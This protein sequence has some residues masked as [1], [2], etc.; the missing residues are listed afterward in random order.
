MQRLTFDTTQDNSSPLWSPDGTRIVFA[1]RRD[2]KWGLYVKSANGTGNEELIVDSEP[3]KAPMSWSP[4]GKILVYWQFG[5]LGDIWAVP[6]AGDKKA[7]PILQSAFAEVFP[8][9]SP[10]GKW[11]AYQSN[12]TGR[13]E[14]YIKPFPDGPGKWQVSTD[15]GLWPRWRG[16]GKELYFVLA[17]SMWAVDIRVTGSSPEAG[18]PQMLF[19]L[20]GDPSASVA[21]H[22]QYHR[23]AVTADGERFLLSQLSG[24]ASTAGGLADAVA[25]AADGGGAQLVGISPNGVTVVVNWPQMMK[26]N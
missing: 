18:V 7:F 19:T 26:Q 23:F 9:V 13:N 14:I 2:N 12:E 4:D 24:G 5:S 11:L 15:G 17:P 22:P 6:L 16:D 21:N 8:Q 20:G 25:A 3:P 10:D 1:S